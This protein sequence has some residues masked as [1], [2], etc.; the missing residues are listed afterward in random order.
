MKISHKYKALFFITCLPE[1]QEITTFRFTF[2]VRPSLKRKL[3]KDREIYAKNLSQNQIWS[4]LNSHMLLRSNRNEK[5]FFLKKPHIK[6]V[7]KI[8]IAYIWN[9]FDAVNI[10]LHASAITSS[11]ISF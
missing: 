8:S 9:I 7:H 3:G 4:F 10:L 1:V 11:I 6:V 2:S 5:I